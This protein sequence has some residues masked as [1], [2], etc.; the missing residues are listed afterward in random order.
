MLFV[1]EAR[2]FQARFPVLYSTCFDSCRL[3]QLLAGKS[4]AERLAALRAAG[5]AYILVHWGELERYRTPGNYGYSEFVTRP[6]IHD[7]LVRQQALLRPVPIGMP[8]RVIELFQVGVP[9]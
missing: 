7:E 4:R 1:G 9:E 6:L 2:V 3:E 5:V 8:S